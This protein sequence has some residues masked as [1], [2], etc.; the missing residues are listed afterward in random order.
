MNQLLMVSSW[1]YILQLFHEFLFLVDNKLS[2]WCHQHSYGSKVLQLQWLLA[3]VLSLQGQQ[4]LR[5]PSVHV[6]V[7]SPNRTYTTIC[8]IIMPQKTDLPL[9]FLISILQ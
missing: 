9:H 4:S 2:L 3:N 7:L 1:S 5:H 8:M 6:S